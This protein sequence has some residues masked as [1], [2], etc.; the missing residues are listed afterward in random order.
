MGQSTRARRT[1]GAFGGRGPEF[2]AMRLSG[3]DV[4]AKSQQA[5]AHDRRAGVFGDVKLL[6]RKIGGAE[7]GARHGWQ[8]AWHGKFGN[9][10]SLARPY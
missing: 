1:S 5:R 2:Q 7:I 10:G 9:A 4:V 3:E 6:R 8:N